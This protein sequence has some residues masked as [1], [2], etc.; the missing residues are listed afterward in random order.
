MDRRVSLAR[1]TV[2]PERT[3]GAALFADISGFTPLTGALVTGLGASRGAEE[4]TSILNRAYLPLS[5]EIDRYGGSVVVFGG[6][7]LTAWFDG[8]DGCRALACALAAQAAFAALSA[9]SVRSVSVPALTLKTTVAAG[10]VR[11]LL[12][13]DPSLNWIDVL[14]GSTMRHLAEA[15]ALTQRGEVVFDVDANALHPSA[16][17]AREWRASRSG[18][19]CAVVD[20]LTSTVEPHPWPPISDGELDAS[21]CRP[22]LLPAVY[23]RLA[24]R[25]GDFL[26]ELR[27]TVSLFLRFGDLDYDNDDEAGAKLDAFVR[28][29]QGVVTRYDGT[30]LGVVIGDKGNHLYATFGAPIAHDDDPHRALAAALDLR[31]LPHH[32]DFIDGVEIGISAGQSWTGS[33]GGTTRDYTVIGESVNL[34]AR[35][36]EA[37]APGQV[38]VS[39]DLAEVLRARYDVL[40]L[41]AVHVKGREE[42][43][44]IASVAGRAAQPAVRLQSPRF[45]SGLVGR[46][47]ELSRVQ[48][49]LAL[50]LQGQGQIVT[51]FGEPGIGK[52]RLAAEIM[53]HIQDQGIDSYSGEAESTGLQSAYFAWRP[54]WHAFFDVPGAASIDEQTARLAEALTAIDPA[55][56]PRLPLLAAA[57]GLPFPDSELTGQMDAGLRKESLEALLVECVRARAANGALVLLL[58]DIQWLDSLSLDLLEA[59][60]RAIVE[61]SVLLL[62][63]GHP[64]KEDMRAELAINR[65]PHATDIYLTDLSASETEELI[66][67]KVRALFNLQS[68]PPAS[69][70]QAVMARTEGNPLY[71]EELLAYLHDRR[72]SPQGASALS[73]SEIPAHLTSV[74]LGRIDQFT[75]RQQTTLKV[76]SIVGR[77]FPVAWLRG[78]HKDVGTEDMV[79]Q[80][81]AALVE[82]GLLAPLPEDATS[83]SFKHSL[84]R[85]AAYGSLPFAFRARLHENLA[86]W[87]EERNQ[88]NSLLDLV[89]YHYGHS[90]NTPRQREYYRKAGDAARA[91]YANADAA[92]YY[93]KLAA[94]AEPADRAVALI[95]LAQTQESLSVWD[96]AE[97][98]YRAVLDLPVEYRPAELAARAELGIGSTLRWRT[99]YPEALEW[100][101]RACRSFGAAGDEIGVSDVLL[102]TAFI[103]W[104]QNRVPEARSAV[105]EALAMAEG[106]G[107]LRQIGDAYH[108]LGSLATLEA[109]Y[110]EA[111]AWWSKSLAIREQIGDR[112][113]IAATTTNLGMI[114]FMEGRYEKHRRSVEQNLAI[115][116]ELG[117]RRLYGI[118]LSAL[119]EA[120][121]REG[122]AVAARDSMSQAVILFRDLGLMPDMIGTLVSLAAI[123]QVSDSARDT[124]LY[125]ARVLAGCARLMETFQCA[126]DAHSGQLLEEVEKRTRAHLGP[127]DYETAW[128]EGYAM[129]WADVVSY[130]LAPS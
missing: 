97:R 6:D 30:L 92:D 107:N 4:M 63:T 48:E 11:R 46:K 31:D 42:P 74:I 56:T 39:A 36:M 126:L 105:K 70:V 13:G 118:N 110:S 87:L 5:T 21:L 86:N 103:Y 91:R 78:V 77:T 22:W 51:I 83:Y 82:A 2:L 35:L 106:Q 19:R 15:A 75:I 101:E 122:D 124:N 52:S 62:L 81:L 57:L 119:A 94:V 59:I 68:T 90:D 79:R 40:P 49:K 80:D 14:A 16:L 121:L 65:L 73:Q 34:A 84:I 117:Y 69:F 125:A 95:S 112:F 28:W 116:R 114:D 25:Q 127:A 89:A 85:D 38:L 29:V 27:Q 128:A 111:E 67:Q 18:R 76:A 33:Y 12:V 123:A 43:V 47:A 60:G 72:I 9:T 71:V 50:A 44:S 53:R 129:E 102:M 113:G 109:N 23:A 37:A 55:F 88:D 41:P 108:L 61:T 17:E 8:D 3:Q 64:P 20:R 1:K 115:G 7:A 100:L 93:E 99:L 54:V 58:E 26:A 104:R 130:A 96:G 24:S 98:N 10:P 66:G 120:Q 32:L 45:A